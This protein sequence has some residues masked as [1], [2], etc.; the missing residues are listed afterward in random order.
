MAVCRED[1]ALLLP[2]T[3]ALYEALKT[4]ILLFADQNE[5]QL[6]ETSTS[7]NVSTP[8]SLSMYIFKHQAHTLESLFQ[9]KNH[10]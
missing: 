3:I 9:V 8:M 4:N 5:S 1:K 6:Q 10:R 2:M 7:Q